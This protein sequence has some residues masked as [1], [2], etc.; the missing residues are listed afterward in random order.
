MCVYMCVY[1]YIHECGCM[2]VY[3]N[4]WVYVCIH[5]CVGV[6]HMYHLSS[7]KG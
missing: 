4:V 6:L 7:P 1:V 5:E 3:M 2:C